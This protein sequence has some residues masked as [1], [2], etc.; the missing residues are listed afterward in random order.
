MASLSNKMVDVITYIEQ[1]WWEDNGTVP[2]NEK[3]AEETG[4]AL[5]TIAD[6]WKDETFRVALSARGITFDNRPD[7]KALT[8]KQLQVANMMM[9][10]LDRRSMREKLKEAGIL[11]QELA[12]WMRSPAF[13]EHLRR[14]GE[15]LFQG[16]DPAAYKGLVSA[17]EAGDLKAIQLFF[18]MRGIYNPKLQVSLDLNVIFIRIIEIISKHVTDP[19]T[20]N[21]IAVEMESLASGPVGESPQQAAL[22]VGRRS[23][24][25]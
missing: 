15:N 1:M 14:R 18:E 22:P 16:A 7:S 5:S 21:A 19:A 2:T 24:Q 20:L 13:Q 3:V 6:Y 4:V 8:M 11:P 23:I 12:G 10:T 9:N 25:I 17:V